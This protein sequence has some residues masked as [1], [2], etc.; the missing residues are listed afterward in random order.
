MVWEVRWTLNQTISFVS[1]I[2]F[3]SPNPFKKFK[4]QIKHTHRCYHQQDQCFQLHYPL[5]LVGRRVFYC[6]NWLIFYFT[7]NAWFN[8]CWYYKFN[9][10][11][12]Q[13]GSQLNITCSSNG[14]SNIYFM[15]NPTNT[16]I[17]ELCTQLC[18]WVLIGK[19][20]WFGICFLLVHLSILLF[21]ALVERYNAFYFIPF[22][23]FVGIFVL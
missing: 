23:L 15:Q 6:L 13:I 21:E 8:V 18:S 1:K 12:S 19:G 5:L 4:C 10:Q 3:E 2:T 20:L 11:S 9:L 16:Q 14:K 22:A 17:K 7:V